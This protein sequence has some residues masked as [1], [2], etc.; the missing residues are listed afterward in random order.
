MKCSRPWAK[1]YLLLL[2]FKVNL[3]A[4][5]RFAAFRKWATHGLC[6]LYETKVFCFFP[7]LF[8]RHLSKWDLKSFQT[9]CV[10]HYVVDAP[11]QTP[12]ERQNPL[13]NNTLVIIRG[14]TALVWKFSI[15]LSAVTEWKSAITLIPALLM[16]QFR[17]SSRTSWP[18]SSAHFSMLSWLTTSSS[19]THGRRKSTKTNMNESRRKC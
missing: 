16:R 5:F 17:P 10:F 4:C 2:S 7:L 8:L 19:D 18:T 15:I 6:W 1:G 3:L 14:A 12:Q 13:V 9:N 11:H